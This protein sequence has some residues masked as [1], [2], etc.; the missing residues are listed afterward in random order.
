MNSEVVMSVYNF[1]VYHDPPEIE[2]PVEQSI[3]LIVVGRTNVAGRLPI[4][5]TT[6]LK[7]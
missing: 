6:K 3:T 1:V 2:L 5:V 7:L 4:A